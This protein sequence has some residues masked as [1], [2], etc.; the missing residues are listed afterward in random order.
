MHVHDDVDK[1]LSYPV[2]QKHEDKRIPK[3]DVRIKRRIV[4]KKSIKI[5]IKINKYR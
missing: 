2:G 1:L 3:F 5:R 4:I